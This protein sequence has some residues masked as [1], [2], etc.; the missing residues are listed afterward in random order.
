MKGIIAQDELKLGINA[1]PETFEVLDKDG[2]R[3][4]TL[5]TIGTNLKG[6]L[7]ESTAVNELKLQAERLAERIVQLKNIEPENVVKPTA[8]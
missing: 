8:S 7:W 4:K 6:V 2:H 5:Y 3:N 1:D